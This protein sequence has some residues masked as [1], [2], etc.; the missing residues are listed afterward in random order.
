MYMI[1]LVTASSKEEAELI[2]SKLINEKLA[3]CA[4]IIE[5]VHSIFR[6]KGKVDHEREV[7]LVVKSHQDKL[8]EIISSVKAHH[9]YDVPEVIAIPILGGNVDYLNW[10]KDSIESS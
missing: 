6:W 3:A 8:D 1:V 5:D 2:A 9:S 10:I 4:N 7:L